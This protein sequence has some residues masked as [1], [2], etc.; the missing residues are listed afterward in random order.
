MGSKAGVIKVAAARLGLSLEEYT[1]NIEAGLK[2]CHSCKSWQPRSCF[3]VDRHRG[4]GLHAKCQSCIRVKE[5]KSTKG[6]VSTFKGRTHTEEAR[7]KIGEAHKGKRLRLGKRHSV[8]TRMKISQKA[9][10]RAR[11][12]SELPNWK[13]GITVINRGIRFSAEYKR[14]RFDVFSRDRFTCQECGDNRGGNLQA[15]HIKSFADFPELR[16]AVENGITL[17]QNCHEQLHLKPIPTP[18]DLRRRKKHT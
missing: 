11:S 13:G 7:R 15:H 3:N 9:R 4:D 12:G 17:C 16:F 10:A 18:A 14:W 8:E 5:R 2:W 1:A 6:R